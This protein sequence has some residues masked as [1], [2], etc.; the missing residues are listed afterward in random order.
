M[1][2][3]LG[4]FDDVGCRAA[5]SGDSEVLFQRFAVTAHGRCAAVS[6]GYADHGRVPLF[7]YLLPK[8][9]L[10]LHVGALDSPDFN[11]HARHVPGEPVFHFRINAGSRLR[12]PTLYQP[13]ISSF[14]R[15]YSTGV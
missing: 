14:L 9:R 8:F 2:L 10:V 6:A 3:S 1:T 7:G 13:G 5:D 12:P 15:A 11:F 4:V